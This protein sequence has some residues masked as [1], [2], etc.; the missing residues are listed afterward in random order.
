MVDSDQMAQMAPTDLTDLTDPT[1]PMAH[2]VLLDQMDLPDPGRH[3][4]VVAVALELE[5]HRDPVELEAEVPMEVILRLEVPVTGALQPMAETIHPVVLATGVRPALAEILHPEV[6]EIRELPETLHLETTVSQVLE[7][8]DSRQ[9]VAIR[10]QALQGS[11]P[12]VHI[13]TA[14]STAIKT[15][16]HDHWLVGIFYR[17]K[18]RNTHTQK[19]IQVEAK[20][21]AAVVVGQRVIPLYLGVSCR[22]LIYCMLDWV[23]ATNLHRAA[24]GNMDS[25]GRAGVLRRF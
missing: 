1:D 3:Q 7:A 2:P 13:R 6:P 12:Q 21:A 24:I 17:F 4:I 20:E 19:L 16:V 14:R 23:W 25:L 18:S 9:L 15:Q 22:C 5:D 11:V 10:P 8:T